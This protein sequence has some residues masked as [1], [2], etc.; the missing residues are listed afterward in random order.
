MNGVFSNPRGLGFFPQHVPSILK[1][2]EGLFPRNKEKMSHFSFTRPPDPGIGRKGQSA[3][4]LLMMCN[5]N[6]C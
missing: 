3:K 5:I 6:S 2:K 4:Y 1:L